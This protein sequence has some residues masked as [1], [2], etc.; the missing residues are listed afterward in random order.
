MVIR[1][2][3]PSCSNPGQPIETHRPW[4]SICK[5]CYLK[6]PCPDGQN[7]KGML[8]NILDVNAIVSLEKHWC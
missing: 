2:I 7:V 1:L 5:L 4:K 6:V 3:S 8:K